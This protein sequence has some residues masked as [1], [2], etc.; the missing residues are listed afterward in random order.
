MGKM[1]DYSVA[2]LLNRASRELTYQRTFTLKALAFAT[3]TYPAIKRAFELVHQLDNHTLAL[4]QEAKAPARNAQ[5][6]G[7]AAAQ[8]Y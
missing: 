1:A 3:A 6:P 8:P 2:I 4:R 5:A 7:A